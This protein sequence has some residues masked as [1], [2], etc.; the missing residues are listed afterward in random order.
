MW[1]EKDDTDRQSYVCKVC[2]GN[3]MTV[4]KEPMAR[5][6][7]LKDH[8]EYGLRFCARIQSAARE[9]QSA[10]AGLQVEPVCAAAFAAARS[11]P[12]AIKSQ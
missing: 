2:H 11:K 9:R 8:A 1:T 6:P 7:A 4:F 3:A 5:K 12:G 10:S